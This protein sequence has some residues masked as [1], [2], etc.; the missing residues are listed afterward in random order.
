MLEPDKAGP[1]IR[2]PGGGS[3]N[4]LL[5]RL[6]QQA[7]CLQVRC[8]YVESATIGNFALQ[9]AQANPTKS[10]IATIAGLKQRIE[11]LEES[12]G[13]LLVPPP[14]FPTPQIIFQVKAGIKKP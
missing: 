6:T 9:L 13:R 2:A 11:W 4:T 12:I 8:G 3:R 14:F 10:E 5:N 1:E 7:T